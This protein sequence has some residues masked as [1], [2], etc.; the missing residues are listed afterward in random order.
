MIIT[1]PASVSWVTKSFHKHSLLWS[2]HGPFDEELVGPFYRTRR[3]SSGREG[4]RSWGWSRVTGPGSGSLGGPEPV[5]TPLPQQHPSEEPDFSRSPPSVGPPVTR[6]S[7]G[8]SVK[9]F[10]SPFLQILGVGWVGRGKKQ[11]GGC[12]SPLERKLWGAPLSPPCWLPLTL[13]PAEE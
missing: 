13:G 4:G 3:R 8:S 7:A 9:P 11:S 10:P 5:Q 6:P 12:M 1:N 2:S